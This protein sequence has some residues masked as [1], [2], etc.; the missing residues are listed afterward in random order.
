MD[1]CGLNAFETSVALNTPDVNERLNVDDSYDNG[2]RFFEGG[3]TLAH[4]WLDIRDKPNRCPEYGEC[5]FKQDSPKTQIKNRDF[6]K[7]KENKYCCSHCGRTFATL[8]PFFVHQQIHRGDGRVDRPFHCCQC[9]KSFY[10][11]K[12]LQ[13]HQQ[14]HKEKRPHRCQKCGNLFTAKPFLLNHMRSHS[15][16]R[17][18]HSSKSA[19]SFFQKKIFSRNMHICSREVINWCSQSN[20]NCRTKSSFGRLKPKHTKKET[21]S[22]FKLS[23]TKEKMYSCSHCSRTFT[24]LKDYTV[25][26][27]IHRGVGTGERPF[28]CSQ[29]GKRFYREHGLK[30]HEQ[31]HMTEKVHC[32]SQCGKCFRTEAVLIRHKCSCLKQRQECSTCV[33]SF[34]LKST[35]ESHMQI[36][37]G[38][39]KFRVYPSVKVSPTECSYNRHKEIHSKTKSY[40]CSRCGRTFTA[41]TNYIVHQQI[42]RGEGKEERPFRCCQCGK[43]FYREHGLRAHQQIHVGGRRHQVSLCGNSFRKN[44][45]QLCHQNIHEGQKQYH[46]IR[47]HVGFSSN[48]NENIHMHSEEQQHLCFQSGEMF[49]AECS[50]KRH[51]Q[52]NCK[53]RSGCCKQMQTKRYCCSY[54]GKVFTI[55]TNYVEH[56][57]S[58][59]AQGRTGRPALLSR[60]RNSVYKPNGLKSHLQTA[61]GRG[62]TENDGK[63]VCRSHSREQ[64]NEELTSCFC[65]YS[66][67]AFT[68]SAIQAQNLDILIREAA[69]CDGQ[70]KKVTR[71]TVVGDGFLENI[72]HSKEYSGGLKVVLAKDSE[73]K[74]LNSIAT[75][76]L[77]NFKTN[78]H[79][80]EHSAH[81]EHFNDLHGIETQDDTSGRPHTE[82]KIQPQFYPDGACHTLGINGSS[83]AVK[84]GAFG[85]ESL[86][87]GAVWN[88]LNC[89]ISFESKERPWN[90]EEITGVPSN[91]ESLECDS[92]KEVKYPKR[93]TALVK[94]VKQEN[95]EYEPLKDIPV[96]ENHRLLQDILDER[97]GDDFGK[98]GFIVKT[99]FSATEMNIE[100]FNQHIH[101]HSN[102]LMENFSSP[103]NFTLHLQNQAS[104]ETDQ[105]F[106]SIDNMKDQHVQLLS[107]TG[108]KCSIEQMP[109]RNKEYCCSHCGKRFSTS[110]KYIVHLQIH[111]EGKDERQFS[112]SL[113]GKSFYREEGLKA[114]KLTH[115]GDQSGNG[116][117]RKQCWK[118][119]RLPALT[120][121]HHNDSAE[122]PQCCSRWDESLTCQRSFWARQQTHSVEST[123]SHCVGTLTDFVGKQRQEMD[124]GRKNGFIPGAL[125]GHQFEEM[126][127]EDPLN[128]STLTPGP[129][130]IAVC[131]ESFSAASNEK[132]Q[133]I[134]STQSALMGEEKP[135]RSEKKPSWVPKLEILD[136]WELESKDQMKA[137]DKELQQKTIAPPMAQHQL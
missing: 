92:N 18:F 88:T 22:H 122:K 96:E 67:K 124:T 79:R 77:P 76:A 39:K 107:S 95:N 70:L 32:C 10:P 120:N 50:L 135:V 3:E 91:E 9:G 126:F 93:G 125:T 123:N 24:V 106:S 110:V 25:H 115:K 137:E 60:S 31:S 46:C 15:R 41:L 28:G 47:H 14:S 30:L 42:H 130:Q 117:R 98:Q 73:C 69:G 54:C 55:L 58:H 34:T 1:D 48:S 33:K 17:Y 8:M 89:G 75:E 81:S 127:T 128:G 11:E 57:Q 35:L 109:T 52:A 80:T 116:S 13:T 78:D 59:R 4:S 66:E 83:S 40:C 44:A 74:R 7:P 19:H 118:P 99:E 132:M 108:R 136:D 104:E 49:S 26:L 5:F 23:A 37:S 64:K 100:Y 71:E 45:A 112:C 90:T 72:F 43:R 82:F 129:S 119:A 105:H 121:H 27:Q 21:N 102:D 114:H 53:K 56:Q 133:M 94:E 38:G 113:C 29:C 68:S 36:H 16:E 103:G 86:M 101:N 111:R 87:A 63:I 134:H 62:S 2:Q 84:T 85:D 12:R 20:R 131:A 51:K 61:T 97:K 6:V 65:S